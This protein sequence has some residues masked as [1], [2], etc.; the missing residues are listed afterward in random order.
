MSDETTAPFNLNMHT[1]RLL[2][3]EPFFAALS[4]RIDKTEVT[5][6]PT[7]AVRVNP[8]RA[9]F[10]LMYNSEFMSSLD[11]EHRLGVLMHEFYHIIF[12]HVTGR[13]PPEGI[14][15]IDNIAMDLAING[16]PEMRG[17]LPSESSPGPE[18]N[19]EPMKA[20]VAALPSLRRAKFR[21]NDVM[22]EFRSPSPL[23]IRFH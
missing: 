7:A 22:M 1:A 12:E 6:L 5:W 9:Q 4:R 17:K 20:C 13:K 23:S 10:E 21:L 2:M 18:I 15:R 8:E 19:G 14:Q 11:D 16:L 3:R